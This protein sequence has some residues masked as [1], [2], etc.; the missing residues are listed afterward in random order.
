M[1]YKQDLFWQEIQTHYPEQYRIT[2]DFF[3]SEYYLT[4]NKIKIHIDHYKKI[5][6]AAS[7]PP[8]PIRA[9][10]IMFHDIGTNGRLMSCFAASLKNHNIEI[11]CP[12][13]PIFGHTDYERNITYD[14][15]LRCGEEVIKHFY[16]DI[17]IFLCGFGI[18]GMLCY[19]IACNLKSK[20]IEGIIATNLIDYRNPELKKNSVRKKFLSK[21]GKLIKNNKTQFLNSAKLPISSVFNLD[22]FT[23]NDEL[24]NLLSKDKFSW[25]CN[26][27]IGFLKTLLNFDIK[28]E[29]SEFEKCPILLLHPQNDNFTDINLSK[30]FYDKIEC[31]KEC[32]I[33]ENGSHYPTEE[34]ALVQFEKRVIEFIDERVDLKQTNL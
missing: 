20:K 21:T 16:D 24:K 2:D 3:P 28:V 7:T 17:P 5:S 14:Y 11:I 10:I 27:E 34:K 1:S 8:I 9:K 19:Q 31:Q 26:I 33:L 22:N 23:N 30:L 15:W 25:D 18:S 4:T 6:S 29:A 32:Y 12:D 13:L